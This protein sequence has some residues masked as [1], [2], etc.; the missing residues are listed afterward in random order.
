MMWTKIEMRCTCY[1]PKMRTPASMDD[2]ADAHLAMSPT[3]Y[4][5]TSV[6]HA[7]IGLKVDQNLTETGGG[8]T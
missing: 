2:A 6:R 4:A 3:E 7:C 1:R 8:S 5:R